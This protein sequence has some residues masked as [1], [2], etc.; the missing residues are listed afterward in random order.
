MEKIAK[1]IK[2]TGK[3]GKVMEMRNVIAEESITDHTILVDCDDINIYVDGDMICG[4]SGIINHPQ[5]GQVIKCCGKLIYIAP[6]VLSEVIALDKDW[7]AR[8]RARMDAERKLDAE[9][10]KHYQAVSNMMTLN[11]TTY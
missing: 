6:E 2:W 7:Q 10:N 4:Y 5:Y 8:L 9:Y 11:G 3:T 1:S